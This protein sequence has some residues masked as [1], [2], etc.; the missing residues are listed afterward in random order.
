MKKIIITFI[1]LMIIAAGILQAE[2]QKQQPQKNFFEGWKKQLKIKGMV[3]GGITSQYYIDISLKGMKVFENKLQALL[4]LKFVEG[5]MKREDGS[6]RQLAKKQQFV[7]SLSYNLTKI[8]SIMSE[9]FLE[10]DK[11]M[12]IDHRVIQMAA[13]GVKV[14]NT[15]M[16]ELLLAPGI[17]GVIERRNSPYPGFNTNDITSVNWGYYEVF[18]F[19]FSETLHF[20]QDRLYGKKTS[21]GKDYF[22]VMTLGLEKNITPTMSIELEHRYSYEYIKDFDMQNKVNVLSG[23]F[24]YKF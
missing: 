23:A 3:E 9:T 24:T 12:Y 18:N 11:M 5:R 21:A 14:L 20:Q 7:C 2:E 19:H 16:A 13:V 17:G 4:S 22:M 10:K 6:K 15:Q 1:C 8:F